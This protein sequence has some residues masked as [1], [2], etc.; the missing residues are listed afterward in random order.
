[1]RPFDVAYR[2][3]YT[4]VYMNLYHQSFVVPIIFVISAEPIRR[5]WAGGHRRMFGAAENERVVRARRRRWKPTTVRAIHF[6]IFFITVFFSLSDFPPDDVEVRVV[7]RD[8]PTVDSPISVDLNSYVS[9]FVV[10]LVFP[11]LAKICDARLSVGRL[12]RAV[13]YI[14]KLHSFADLQSKQVWKIS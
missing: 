5:R 8:R 3:A 7:R 1:M 11:L 13:N 14:E 9:F 10:L 12:L 4:T 6:N 2:I